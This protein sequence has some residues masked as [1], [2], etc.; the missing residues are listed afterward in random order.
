MDDGGLFNAAA[1][2]YLLRIS[3]CVQMNKTEI[4][5]LYSVNSHYSVQQIRVD[6]NKMYD[7]TR[8]PTYRNELF[9]AVAIQSTT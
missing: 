5:F 6:I 7:D 3:S 9:P 4:F 1:N 8:G 2:I